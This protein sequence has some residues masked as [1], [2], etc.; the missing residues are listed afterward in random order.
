MENLLLDQ[1]F[2]LCSQEENEDKQE[3][4]GIEVYINE[5]SLNLMYRGLLI[6]EG[7]ED[8]ICKRITI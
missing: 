8:C 3:E 5:E 7:K 4:A 6:Q 1:S 2:W